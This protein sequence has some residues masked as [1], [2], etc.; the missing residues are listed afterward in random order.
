MTPRLGVLCSNC[1]NC[2][3]I[4]DWPGWCQCSKGKFDANPEADMKP[5]RKLNQGRYLEGFA[6]YCSTFEGEEL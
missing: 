5:Y 1:M 4:K 2:K 6:K 3:T